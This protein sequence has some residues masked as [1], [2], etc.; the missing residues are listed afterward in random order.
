MVGS[1]FGGGD[2]APATT[3]NPTTGEGKP[4]KRDIVGVFARA[5]ALLAGKQGPETMLPT[6]GGVIANNLALER[7][8]EVAEPVIAC[9]RRNGAAPICQ[10]RRA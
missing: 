6:Q 3:F 7:M 1:V 4:V 10:C 9:P 2:D 8:P 5:C